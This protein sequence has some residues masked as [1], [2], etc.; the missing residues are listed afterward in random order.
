MF[1]LKGAIYSTPCRPKS[2]ATNNLFRAGGGSRP[3]EMLWEWLKELPTW[4]K[5][6][7]G[8]G[9]VVAGAYAWAKLYPR[10]W[11]E[12]NEANQ[13]YI[14]S[15]ADFGDGHG[16]IKRKHVRIIV[17]N[18]GLKA[19]KGCRV[20]LNRIEEVTIDGLKQLNYS[21]PMR[22]LWAKEG[23]GKNDDTR[24]ISKGEDFVDVLRTDNRVNGDQILLCDIEHTTI[25]EFK[26]RY[27]ISIVARTED[28]P[29]CAL[30]FDVMFGATWD[31]VQVLEPKSLATAL[32][33][34][35][36][37]LNISQHE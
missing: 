24:T 6:L 20:F 4:L 19:A 27:R 25:L 37:K 26:K 35:L 8:V 31:C 32:S 9:S 33:G 23:N 11:L 2:L 28:V 17:H 7:S 5:S 12:F 13:C 18:D 21:T 36:L 3:F 14:P 16:L 1:C 22:L 34:I 15:H 10:L 30:T 29:A